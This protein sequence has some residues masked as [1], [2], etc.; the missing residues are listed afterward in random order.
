MNSRTA[1]IA[2]ALRT[3]LW[4]VPAIAVLVALAL[5]T[6][7]PALDA[8]LDTKLPGNISG[9]LFGGGP[10]AARAVLQ[11]IAGS[12]ITVTSLTFSLTVVTLQ[13]ASSQFSPRVLRTFAADK[14][15]HYTLA[16]FMSA[17]AFALTVLRTVRSASGPTAGFVPEISVTLAFL[18]SIASILGLVLFLAHLTREIRAETMMQRVADETRATLE[19]CFPP[20]RAPWRPA[21]PAGPGFIRIEAARTGF[22]T[23]VDYQ[24]LIRLAVA[25]GAVIRIDKTPGSSVI[26]GVPFATAWPLDSSLEF[27]L[28]TAKRLAKGST[29]A[30]H[31]GSERTHVQDVAFGFRQ[32]VDVAARALSPGVNDPTTAVH[33]LGHLSGL[34]C[35]LPARMPGTQC[36][37]DEQNRVRVVLTLP[38][39]ADLLDLSMA[40][41]RLYGTSDP[42]VAE[43][44]LELLQE[45]SWSDHAGS[46]RPVILHQAQN[47]ETAIKSAGHLP[48]KTAE[49]LESARALVAA[50]TEQLPPSA[51]S[52]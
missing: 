7:L 39:L 5:G 43:R 50:N 37:M 40:Q 6:V 46:Y 32:L 28:E 10:D 19:R 38:E 29:K 4:P 33:V 2:D 1:R 26:Q 11:A 15:V 18:L 23:S 27:D 31:T 12:L 21:P 42:E 3:Q 8:A 25:E 36:L 48:Q 35:Q 22:L 30:I 17:F 9:F 41:P 13:L 16:L 51:S 49:L 20:D 44:L 45:L 47:M 52:L 24:E 14:F 34:L